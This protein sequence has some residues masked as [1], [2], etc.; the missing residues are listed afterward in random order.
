M[1]KC[2]YG[3]CPKTFVDDEIKVY[4]TVDIFKKYRKFKI[5]QLKLNHPDKNYVNCPFPDCEEILDMESVPESDS[6]IECNLGHKFCAKCKTV[7]WHKKGN[8]SNV[9]LILITFVCS[10]IMNF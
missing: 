9:K 4:V 7:G 6:M 8:C 3:G 5:S 2:L 1:I 10:M